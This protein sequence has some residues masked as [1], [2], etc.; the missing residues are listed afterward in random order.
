MAKYVSNTDAANNPSARVPVCL[1]LDLSGSMGTIESGNYVETGETEIIDGKKYIIV[2]GGTTRL[3]ELLGGIELLFE[4]IREDEMAI[5]AAEIAIIG[6]NDIARCYLDFDHIENQK[7]P[8]LY[9]S[10]NTAMGEG[11]NL[12]LRLLE[13]RKEF[14]KSKGIQYYQPWLVLM[15]DGENNGSSFELNDAIS[16]TT[17]LINKKKLTIF[18][19][20]IGKEADMD[21]LAKFSPKRPPMRLKG[22]NFKEFFVWLSQSISRTSVSKPGDTVHLPDTGGWGTL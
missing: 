22:M 3:D 10:G 20:G 2:E 6:F 18:P 5:D 17:D 13:E 21:T 7:V 11:V 8:E 12:A 4:S 15:T 14:Y 16:K 19:I 1:C 9:A